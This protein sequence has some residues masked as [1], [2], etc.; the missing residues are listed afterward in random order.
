MILVFT[1]LRVSG[2]GQLR[3][4][5]FERQRIA[6]HTYARGN[7][8][9]IVREYCERAV[10]GATELAHRPALTE[11]LE[12]LAGDGVR[13][14]LIERLDRLARNLMTQESI[15]AEIHKHSFELISALEPD[16]LANDPTRIM[17]RQILGSVAQYDKSMIVAKLRGA[18]ERIRAREGR[19]EG[20]KPF[21]DREG[22]QA[23]IQSMRELQAQGFTL[24]RIAE[25]L[26]QEG[27]PTRLRGHWHA[28]MVGRNLKRTAQ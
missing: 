22:E 20:R 15:L 6:C 25:Q 13:T 11:L 3:G 19:C 27:R 24:R 18:R 5:G 21:G 8:L 14:I 9:R 12:A 17:L 4:D 1:Y 7:N 10:P 26:N 28:T 23:V 2:E 16:L